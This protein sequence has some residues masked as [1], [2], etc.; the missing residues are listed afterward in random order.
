MFWGKRS[1]VHVHVELCG[2][3]NV[4]EELQFQTHSPQSAQVCMYTVKHVECAFVK[5]S[6][7]VQKCASVMKDIQQNYCMTRSLEQM[8]TCTCI[9]MY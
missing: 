1:C 4:L 3:G 6:S 7:V 8:T 2:V 9:Y 5:F